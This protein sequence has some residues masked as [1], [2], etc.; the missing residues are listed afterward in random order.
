MILQYKDKLPQIS[1]KAYV[2]KDTTV[3]GDVSIGDFSSIWYGSVLRGDVNKI[4]VGRYSNI[5]DGCIVHVSSNADTV[6]G[7]YVTVGHRAIIHGCKIGNYVLIGMGTVV[8][9]NVAIG[10]NVI[11]GAGTLI[12][13]GKEIPSNSMVYGDP[14]RI[15]RELTEEEIEHIRGSAFNYTRL[16]S[17]HINI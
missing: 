9:D 14:A 2:L 12:T 16:A 17:E 4:I 13:G 10:D 8:L 7:D 5:Q 15:V 3:I 11:I 1:P 6:I